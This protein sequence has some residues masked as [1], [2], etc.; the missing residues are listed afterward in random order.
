MQ[1]KLT[2]ELAV[3]ILTKNVSVTVISRFKSNSINKNDPKLNRPTAILIYNRNRLRTVFL[4]NC[5]QLQPTV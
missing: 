4:S 5:G 2:K 1:H 3:K